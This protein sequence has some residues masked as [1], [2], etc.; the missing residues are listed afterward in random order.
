MLTDL[1]VHLRPDDLDR[2]A[3][4]HFTAENVRNPSASIAST[5]P[6]RSPPGRTRTSAERTSACAHGSRPNSSSPAAGGRNA[7]PFASCHD[8]SGLCFF[9]SSFVRSRTTPQTR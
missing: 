5:V 9:R 1:H 3:A 6:G 8:S 2:S 4:D 7:S